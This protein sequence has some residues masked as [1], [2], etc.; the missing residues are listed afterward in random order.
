MRNSKRTRKGEAEAMEDSS[1]FK[2]DVELYVFDGGE[3][4][5]K[6]KSRCF[7]GDLRWRNSRIK[8]KSILYTNILM[9][10]Y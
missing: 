6:Q 2:P 3:H 8:G 10:F 7:E 1:C 4:S 5:A 9:E